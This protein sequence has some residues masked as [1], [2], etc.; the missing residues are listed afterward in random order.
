MDRYNYIDHRVIQMP[1]IVIHNLQIYS[2]E[3]IKAEKYIPAYSSEEYR[4]LE[5]LYMN[6][7]REQRKSLLL[8]H[9]GY[10][11]DW[12]RYSHKVLSVDKQQHVIDILLNFITLTKL[13]VPFKISEIPVHHI[14]D[15]STLL[16]YSHHIIYL[17][18]LT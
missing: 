7:E 13:K 8:H 4:Q 11:E 2:D 1:D 14:I 15:L 17:H 6:Q 10:D 5:L 12:L 3:N 16:H 18:S 9:L